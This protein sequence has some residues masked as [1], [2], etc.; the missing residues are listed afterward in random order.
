MKKLFLLILLLCAALANAVQLAAGPYRLDVTTTPSVIPLGRA[1]IIIK[2]TD[3]TSN[4]VQNATVKVFAQMPGMVMGEREETATNGDG[5]GLYVAPAVFGMAGT[6]EIKI[7]ISGPQ[8]NSVATLNVSTGQSLSEK[9]KPP[10]ALYLGIGIAVVALVL[11]VRQL[12]ATGQKVNVR[13]LLNLQVILSLVLLGGALAIVLWAVNTQRR[14]GS[15]TPL[16]AQVMEMNVPP[17]SGVLP[18]HLVRVE[19]KPLG[20]TVSY[21]GQAVGFV[22]QDL[23]PRVTGTILSMP[24]YVGDKVTKGQVLARLD[25][26]QLDPMVREKT[27]GVQAAREGVN[28]ASM[29]YEQA[30]NMIAEARAD[31]AMTRG[32][33]QEASALLESARQAKGAMDSGVQV[34]ESEVRAM[35]AELASAS[36][37]ATY[38][39]QE[40]QRV[41]LLFDQKAVSRDELQK[42]Q[43]EVQKAEAAQTKA[44]EVVGRTKANVAAAKAGVRKAE[45]DVIAAQRKVA[46]AEAKVR[47]KEARVQSAQAAALASKSKISQSSASVGEATAGL[48]GAGAL[49]ALSELRSEVD[50]VVTQRLISPGTVVSPGQTL[51]KIAQVSPLR[52][53]ANVPEAELAQIK[54]GNTV[55]VTARG[56]KQEALT[57][58]VTSIQPSVDPNSRTGVVE[59]LYDNHSQSLRPGQYI[60]LEISLASEESAL[61]VP[62]DALVI[63]EGAPYVW[64]AKPQANNQFSLAKKKVELGAHAGGFTAII[65]GLSAGQQ[66]VN[67]PPQGLTVESRVTA[68]DIQKS[69]DLVIRITAAGYDP[70]AIQIPVGVA[71]NITFIR[72]DDQS[73]GTEIIFPDLH[74]REKLPLNKPVVVHIP[75]QPA[76]KVLAFTCPMNMLNGKAVAK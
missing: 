53:Q 54:V 5:P 47:A 52:L 51:L 45:A 13:S 17:P 74:I 3:S 57:L 9:P 29:E 49:R 12:R 28:V 10:L 34:A 40:V 16:E 27:A 65:S 14:Q 44:S 38:Q 63:E 58:K 36:A 31:L 72:L 15:M 19:L 48:Q 69:E 20:A 35:Q 67:T 7:S 64:T 2:L 68:A 46:Q 59:A 30:L 56:E 8:G 25:T 73:C 75:P 33:V 11:L 4:P 43:A 55:R 39:R 21:T 22:E 18:V 62:S 32:E 50:G 76:G 1:K 66:V 23:V 42:A 61:V 70:P 60:S 6:Y 37:D 71:F 24:V 41:K 26:T